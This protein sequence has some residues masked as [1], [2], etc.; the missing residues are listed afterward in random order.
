LRHTTSNVSEGADGEDE[1]REI[2]SVEEALYL[3]T[4]GGAAV[5]DMDGELGGFEVG[6]FW[7]V[8]MIRL[9]PTTASAGTAAVSASTT[10][11]GSETQSVVDIFGWES[12]TERVHKWVWSGDDRNV[13]RVWVRGALVHSIDGDGDNNSAKGLVGLA[14]DGMRKDWVRWAFGGV[15]VGALGLILGGRVRRV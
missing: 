7:D 13:R 3:A 10:G 15:G 12:W 5:V 14:A 9:G 2:L 4:R 6:M 11:S 8:Q 1:G